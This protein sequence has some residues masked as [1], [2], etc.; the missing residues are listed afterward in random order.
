[1]LLES[2]GGILLCTWLRNNARPAGCTVLKLT[3]MRYRV[4]SYALQILFALGP[5][6]DR[7]R[8]LAMPFRDGAQLHSMVQYVPPKGSGVLLTEDPGKDMARVCPDLINRDNITLAWSPRRKGDR[9]YGF[10]TE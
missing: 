10:W 1:M 7:F 3:A 4:G 5:D 8:G 9:F 2:A 6:E